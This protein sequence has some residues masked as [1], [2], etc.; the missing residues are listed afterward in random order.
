MSHEKRMLPWIIL[1]LFYRGPQDFGQQGLVSWKTIFHGGERTVQ[2]VMWVMENYWGDRWSFSCVPATHLLLCSMWL[3]TPTF[4]D[5]RR[6]KNLAHKIFLKISNYLKTCTSS[7][8]QS[9]GCLIPDIHPEIFLGSIDWNLCWDSRGHK[10][11]DTTEQLKGTEL[12]CHEVMGPD[13]MTLVFW[14]LNFKPEFSHASF[15]RG[16]RDGEYI[17]K[18]MANSCQCMTKTTTIL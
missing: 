4:L 18:S 16:D 1:V 5:I 3:E 10:E 7:F 13:V 15:P 8:S 12:F 17:Y 11:S 2:V 14:M 6:Y 9:T